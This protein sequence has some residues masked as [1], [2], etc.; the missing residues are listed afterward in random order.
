MIEGFS[1]TLNLTSDQLSLLQLIRASLKVKSNMPV[2]PNY[3]SPNL[4]K[5]WEQA[6]S[7]V[8]DQ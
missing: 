4:L 8:T 7:Q 1:K 3:N 2:L 5:F 6:R